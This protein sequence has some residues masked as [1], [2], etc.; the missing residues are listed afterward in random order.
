GEGRGD[1]SDRPADPADRG[2]RAGR[3]GGDGGPFDALAVA[4]TLVA[5]GPGPPGIEMGAGQ[6]GGPGIR[7]ARMPQGRTRDHAREEL[8]DR[9]ARACGAPR[10]VRSVTWQEW[11]RFCTGRS[12]WGTRGAGRTWPI[13][14]TMR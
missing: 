8:D 14:C 2:A 9:G 13:C 10:E 11:R 6:S 1:R 7:R 5:P 3:A 12:R 4:R